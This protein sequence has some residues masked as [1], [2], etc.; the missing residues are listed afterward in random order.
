[1]IV[2]SPPDCGALA[3]RGD[4]PAKDFFLPLRLEDAGPDRLEEAKYSTK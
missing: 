2:I 4:L 1:M 3:D